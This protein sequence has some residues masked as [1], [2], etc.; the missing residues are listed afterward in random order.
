MTIEKTTY[1]IVGVVG[2]MR[3]AGPDRPVR[4]EVYLPYEG[5][6]YLGGTFLIRAGDDPMAALA[7]VKSA[8]WRVSPA[9]PVTE[10][11]T[12]EEQFTRATARRRFSML[13]MSVFAALALLI[14]TTGVYGVIAFVVCQRARE[15]GVRLAL[16][17][18]T[19]EVV[20]LFVRQ[21]VVVILAGIGAGLIGAW[22]L[23]QTVRSYLFE[24][25]PVTRSCSRSSRAFSVWW[26]SWPAG[27]RR[28]APR[29]WIRWS[30][31][32]RSSGR[33]TGASVLVLRPSR[34]YRPAETTVR[35]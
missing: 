21:A 31:C 12:A 2:D 26:E 34:L 19:S 8:I 28:A 22:C 10:V 29:A 18:R 3:Y 16:G 20:G 4:P 14:A 27:S 25:Q 15:I 32:A 13:L 24:V 11:R 6:R 9:L 23:A 1:E 33:V 5:S 7:A 35:G 30:R 17:A